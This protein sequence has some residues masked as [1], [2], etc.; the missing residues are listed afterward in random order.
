LAVVVIMIVIMVMVRFN[1]GIRRQTRSQ[2]LSPGDLTLMPG[3]IKHRVWIRLVAY[4]LC[5]RV[6]GFTVRFRSSRR[7]AT[8]RSK[9]LATSTAA[10]KMSV[11]HR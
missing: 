2:V 11:T 10:G 1:P 8:G 9:S 4:S 7:N 5:T 3:F 6:N